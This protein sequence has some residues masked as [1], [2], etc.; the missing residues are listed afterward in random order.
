MLPI[1]SLRRFSLGALSACVLFLHVVSPVGA[2][3]GQPPRLHARSALLVEAVSGTVLYAE[4]VDQ[5]IPPASLTKLMTLHLALE[6]IAAGRLDPAH[7]VLPGPD[8]WAKNMPA[9]S[10]LMFLGPRQRLTVEELLRGLVVVSGNDAAVE[11]A[12]VVAGSV[13]AFVKMM[14]DEAAR[15]GYKAMHFVE[16]AGISPDNVIT[17]REY[18]DFCRRFVELHPDAMRDLFTVKQLS[19]PLPHNLLPGNH[20]KP[21]TQPNRNALLGRFEGA[22][23]LK[24]GFIDESG[25]NIAATAERAGMRLIAVVLGV[26]DVGDMN[27]ADVRT[28]ES[29]ALLNYGFDNFSTARPGFDDPRPVHVWKGGARSVALVARPSPL[30]VVPRGRAEALTTRVEQ[31]TDVMAPVRPGQKLGSVIV[32]LGDEELGRFPLVAVASVNRGGLFRRATD[33]VILFFRGLFGGRLP[34]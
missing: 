31:V 33:S 5:G 26:P 22:D 32:M 25:Y 6:E 2:L 24:T 14:N 13:P 15:L 20:E 12:E 11:V 7:T 16:P 21:I 19:Y 17:A 34:A 30:V 9:R 28:V 1:R 27:G 10:S 23:G 4:N 18:M 29:A 3:P 8:A